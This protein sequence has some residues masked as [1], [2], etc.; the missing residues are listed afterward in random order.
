MQILAGATRIPERR[1]YGLWPGSHLHGDVGHRLPRP[2]R[3]SPPDGAV[4]DSRALLSACARS[5]GQVAPRCRTRRARRLLALATPPGSGQLHAGHAHSWPAP[6]RRVPHGV[7]EATH[8][9][10]IASNLTPATFG[11]NLGFTHRGSPPSGSAGSPRRTMDFKINGGL[12]SIPVF[13]APARSRPR[14][15][16]LRGSGPGWTGSARGEPVQRL[17]PGAHGKRGARRRPLLIAAVFTPA[18]GTALQE[19]STSPAIIQKILKAAPLLFWQRVSHRPPQLPRPTDVHRHSDQPGGYRL[20][21]PRDH[22][23]HARRHE[24]GASRDARRLGAGSTRTVTW[25]L[26]VGDHTLRAVYSGNTTFVKTH[27]PGS[28]S[29]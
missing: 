3:P 21:Q 17:C 4:Y 29:G 26:P 2:P 23:V 13:A 7:Q 1:P 16:G 9:T 15:S 25:T 28:S 10:V 22:P 6:A 8:Q 20:A 12:V 11:Q 5:T 18:T 27:Q 24:R 19:A 14:S